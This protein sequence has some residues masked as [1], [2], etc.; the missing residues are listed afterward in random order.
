MSGKYCKQKR[1]LAVK[2]GSLKT[3]QWVIGHVSRK[4]E[5]ER[6][7]RVLKTASE[8]F[9]AITDNRYT[10]VYAPIGMKELKIETANGEI[11]A[12]HQLSRAQ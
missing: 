1:E 3:C 2:W 11:L 7:P 12:P 6:Q 4:Y 5:Q 10:R 8:Y 9:A